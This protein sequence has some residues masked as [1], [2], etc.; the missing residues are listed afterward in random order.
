MRSR[1]TKALATALGAAALAVASFGAM[2]QANAP[3]KFAMCYDISK[4]Y[5]FIS[6]QVIQ[7]AK[8]YAEVINLQGGLE[9]R[10]IEIVV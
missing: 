6:P 2:A 3:I 9:G 1:L 7:A 4:A 8:D 5:T 10:P